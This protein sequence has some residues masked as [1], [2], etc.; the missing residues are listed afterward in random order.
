MVELLAYIHWIRSHS[1]MLETRLCLIVLESP[2]AFQ[3]DLENLT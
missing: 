1:K 3:I 2:K